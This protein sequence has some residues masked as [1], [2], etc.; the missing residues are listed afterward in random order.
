MKRFVRNFICAISLLSASL[1]YAQKQEIRVFSHRGGRME[2][3][4]NTM[5]A[6][7]A[8]YDAGYRGF[9]VDIRLTKDGEMVITH[10]STLERTT[11][12][13]GI[14]EEKTA[15][16]LR[17]L[18]TKKGGK[19]AFL[20]ELLEWL[21]DKE[22]LYVE[23][24]MKTKPEKLYP[25]ERLQAYCDQLYAMVM[26]DKPAD[27]DYVFTSSDYRGLRYLQQKYPGVD[28]LMISSKPCNDETIDLALALGIKRIG[29]TMDGTSR[30]AVKKA[31]EKGLTVSLWPGYTTDDFM[32]GA[33]L[34]ADFMC[35]DIP[36]EL[37]KFHAEKAPWL[38]VKY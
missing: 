6:F 5:A 35:T 24:E 2:F 32:L 19:L 23:F 34:G 4:E 10:D 30:K 29:C 38:N 15:D 14:V 21:K 3:D 27:A 12:G 26:K 31:H 28:L 1:A 20:P 33:Y 36:I 37:K 8:S 18:L 11:N 16:E 17:A 9:E 25:E 22:G 13:T 7:Q